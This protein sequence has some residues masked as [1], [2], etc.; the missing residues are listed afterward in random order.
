M[1]KSDRSFDRAERQQLRDSNTN[2][3]TAILA[4]ENMLEKFRTNAMRVS[5]ISIIINLFLASLKLFAGIFG[6]SKALIA[7][8]IHSASDVFTTVIV[9]V[10]LFVSSKSPDKEHQYGHQKYESLATLILG[11]LLGYV[12]IKIGIDGISSI[13]EKSYLDITAPTLITAIAAVVSIAVK[14]IMFHATMRVAK[15][16]H[17]SALKADA[18]HHRSDA[19]SSIGSL[20]GVV[21]A[22]CGFPIMDAIAS[23]IICIFILKTSIDIIIESVKS[24]T[25]SACDQKT[26]KRLR[27]I[28]LSVDGVSGIDLLKTRVFGSGFY[29]DVEIS[30]DAKLSLEDA[31]S[32]AEKVH[33]KI[34]EKIP[35]VLHCMVHMNPEEKKSR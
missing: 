25:D 28:I 12:G 1:L 6:N 32:I 15:K 8:A 13:I 21:F 3:I 30:V 4:K 23:V 26:I 5:I 24:L 18:W 27:K 33:D 19:L 2:N 11:G 16:E 20:I 7:D 9:I 34:E 10:S 35:E 14:E 31:H 22:M 29:V 17:S